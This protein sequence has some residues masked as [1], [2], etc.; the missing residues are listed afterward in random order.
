LKNVCDCDSN[1]FLR[2]KI[3]YLKFSLNFIDWQNKRIER[4]FKSKSQLTCSYCA[5]IF[6]DPIDLPCEDSI[7]R[8]HLSERDVVKEKR[9]KCKECNGEFQIN[10]DAFRSN[11]TLRK[12]LES[13]SYFKRRRI[14]SQTRIRNV[15]SKVL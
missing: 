2:M 11:K 9:I 14:K 8:E 4:M 1:A 5:K 3:V 12:F 7:C 10:D 13:Q 15:H 6:K